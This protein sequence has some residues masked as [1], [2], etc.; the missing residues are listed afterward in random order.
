VKGGIGMM[1]HW[2]Q[3]VADIMGGKKKGVEKERG[4]GSN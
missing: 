4:S 2:C 3:T 1:K